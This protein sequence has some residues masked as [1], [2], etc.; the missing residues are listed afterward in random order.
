MCTSLSST[1]PYD[2]AIQNVQGLVFSED[3]AGFLA[4]ALAG[5][6]T[7]SKIVGIVAGMEIPAVIKYRKG[8]EAGVAYVCPDCEALGRLH[9]QLHRPGPRQDG[10]PVADG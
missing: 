10:C 4:G 1:T 5:S 6:M 3:Q 8:Y 7:E 9:R 2:P